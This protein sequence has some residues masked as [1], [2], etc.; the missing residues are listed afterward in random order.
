MR[1]KPA[2][3]IQEVNIE[4]NGSEMTCTTKT[5]VT[6]NSPLIK[7]VWY[8]T[9]DPITGKR[10]TYLQ[11][12]KPEGPNSNNPNGKVYYIPKTFADAKKNKQIQEIIEHY[13]ILGYD[14]VE[15]KIN[16][17][18]PIEIKIIK[19]GNHYNRNDDG[20]FDRFVLT[21]PDVGRR[22][23]YK[24][25]MEKFLPAM[26][27]KIS[28]RRLIYIGEQPMWE[29]TEH[30]DRGDSIVRTTLEEIFGDRFQINVTMDTMD[31]LE[32]GHP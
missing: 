31:D 2:N 12:I 22:I 21:S 4:L 27:E 7:K 18:P 26:K 20:V 24:D 28:W 1:S 9:R 6:I 15:P 13:R 17:K 32:W 3:E 5:S 8:K 11:A 30:G 29:Y 19:T 25:W 10:K 16:K 14:I 23:T